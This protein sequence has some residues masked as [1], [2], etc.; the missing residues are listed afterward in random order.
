[1]RNRANEGEERKTDDGILGEDV[2][3]DYD[4]ACYE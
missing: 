1:M 4:I 3:R 2:Y